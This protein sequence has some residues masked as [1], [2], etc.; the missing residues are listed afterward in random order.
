MPEDR[1]KKNTKFPLSHV[2]KLELCNSQK[3]YIY[4]C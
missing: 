3:T 4:L 1:K 2:N